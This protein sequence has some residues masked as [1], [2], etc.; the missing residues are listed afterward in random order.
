ML[1]HIHQKSLQTSSSYY[2]DDPELLPDVAPD[3]RIYFYFTVQLIGA[4]GLTL[5]LAT[6]AWPSK[7]RR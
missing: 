3:W 7:L 4:L 2:G 6:M 5:L 1:F